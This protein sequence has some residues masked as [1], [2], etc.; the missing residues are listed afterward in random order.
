MS[1]GWYNYEMTRSFPHFNTISVN[2]S[3]PKLSLDLHD[4]SSRIISSNTFFHGR[5]YRSALVSSRSLSYCFG[6][7][8]LLE[9]NLLPFE[10]CI[11]RRAG[12]LKIGG[13]EVGSMSAARRK[14]GWRF[15]RLQVPKGRLHDCAPDHARDFFEDVRSNEGAWE[16]WSL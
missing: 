8:L 15:T 7:T 2:L 9:G 3:A 6:I 11:T 13:G 4:L 5:I 12:D 10:V 1:R 14:P 16:C